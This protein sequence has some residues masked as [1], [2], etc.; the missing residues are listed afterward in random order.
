MNG[1]LTSEEM[2]AHADK[3]LY[4]VKDS[5]RDSVKST[6]ILDRNMQPIEVFE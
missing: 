1:S 5:G 6:I 4:R 3:N 2:I